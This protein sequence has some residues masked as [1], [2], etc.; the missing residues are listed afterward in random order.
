MQEVLTAD[1]HILNRSIHGN[2][3]FPSSG[4]IAVRLILTDSTPGGSA[5]LSLVSAPSVTSAL[6]YTP[7]HPAVTV[8]RGTWSQAVCG[9][10]PAVC[11]GFP[12]GPVWGGR[13]P[14]QSPAGHHQPLRQTAAPVTGD[15]GQTAAPVT[16][17]RRQTA[18]PVGGLTGHSSP[19]TSP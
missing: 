8:S 16:G 4:Y 3:I 14:V 5:D 6:P 15:R 18:A 12:S 19:P 11:A 7:P 9:G 13:E 17:D 2:R 1:I 10:P